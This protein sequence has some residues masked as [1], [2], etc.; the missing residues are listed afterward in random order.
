MGEEE[1][2]HL[3]KI[4]HV[5]TKRVQLEAKLG[6]IQR[7]LLERSGKATKLKAEEIWEFRM[8]SAKERRLFQK[9]KHREA[10]VERILRRLKK[11]N[12]N[13]TVLGKEV[14]EEARRV[15][16]ELIN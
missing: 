6:G 4:K 5:R 13:R 14:K 1:N 10:K 9:L 8:S 3:L 11:T 2:K 12:K 16:H 7:K 15:A